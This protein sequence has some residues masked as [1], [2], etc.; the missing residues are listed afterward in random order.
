[1]PLSL[2]SP[3]CALT[4]RQKDDLWIDYLLIFDTLFSLNLDVRKQNMGVGAIRVLAAYTS[5]LGVKCTVFS[6]Q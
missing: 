2:A 3:E 5:W 1:M 6:P 4:G